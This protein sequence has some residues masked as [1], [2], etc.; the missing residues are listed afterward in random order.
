LRKAVAN[1]NWKNLQLE[2]LPEDFQPDNTL[3]LGEI[4]LMQETLMHAILSFPLIQH[5]EASKELKCKIFCFVFS[6]VSIK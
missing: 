2:I 3:L 6:A 1:K 4:P 5:G